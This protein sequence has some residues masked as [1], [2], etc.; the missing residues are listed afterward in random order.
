M[1]IAALFKVH[2]LYLCMAICLYAKNKKVILTVV[3]RY[4]MDTVKM[5]KKSFILFKSHRVST[6]V[7]KKFKKM[8]S[9]YCFL[10]MFVYLFY[11][12]YS[13]LP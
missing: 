6:Y 2:Y 5:F 13:V 1:T 7:K 10:P 4:I 8:F 3:G 12:M 9:R 11:L